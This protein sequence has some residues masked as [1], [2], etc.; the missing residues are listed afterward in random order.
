MKL[1]MVGCSHHNA[2]LEVRERLAFSPDQTRTALVQLRAQFPETE[3]VLISTC[4]RV[5]LYAAASNGAPCPTS[6][7][8]VQFLADFHG[9][10]PDEIAD[11]LHAR[12][13]AEAVRHLF[14]VAAS[15]DSMVVGEAQV[16]S[17]VKQ[18]YELARTADTAGPLTNAAFQ[19]ALHVAKRVATETSINQRRVSV[20]SVAIADFASQIFEQFHDKQVLVIGAGET[21][22]ET[23]RYLIDEG[24]RDITVVNRTP[25]RAADLAARV[26]GRPAPWEEL[27]NH[28]VAA[29]LVI[30]TTGSTEPIVTAGRF[31]AIHDRRQ[32]RPLFVLDLAV[33]RD[34]DPAV[35]TLLGVY[36]YSI[37]DLQ[38]ACDEN[39]RAREKEWPTAQRIVDQ[40]TVRF[41]T[42]LQHR[43]TGPTIQRLKAQVDELKE[44]ELLRLLHKLGAVD[45]RTQHE[46]RIAFDRLVNKLLHPPLESLRDEAERG[47]SHGLLEALKRLF[48]L[49]D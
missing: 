38:A 11:A 5:E 19:A 40:E 44:E 14:A 23:L 35:G 7:E 9:R 29:D 33:P 13:G 42:G 32:Q 47:S 1:Q 20:A 18:A 22:E 24:T 15:L 49:Q 27:D 8:L 30:G 25:E 48:Q 43:A 4:N 46:I 6:A 2:P 17:Q 10:S 26:G 31:A 37:D 39:R 16:L 41:M 3:A 34:F 45:E 12:A 36:L 21:A 28:L